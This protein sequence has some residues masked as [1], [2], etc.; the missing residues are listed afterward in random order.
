MS[1]KPK[2][3]DFEIV[4]ASSINFAK[5]GR[6]SNVDADLVAKLRGVKVGQ[7][8]LI[9]KMALN[10]QASDYRTAKARVSSQLRN[11]C[12]SAGLDTYAI[13]WTLDGVPSIQR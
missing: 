11:A 10:P 7:T 13:R 3:D 1:D 12:A 4:E 2:D 5:R 9:R 6:K 8:V